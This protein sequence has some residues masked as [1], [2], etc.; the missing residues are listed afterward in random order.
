MKEMLSRLQIVIFTATPLWILL[1]HYSLNASVSVLL[2]ISSTLLILNV[3]YVM[4]YLFEWVF[5][6]PFKKG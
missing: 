2:W 1:W 6:K 3:A 4:T 5:V